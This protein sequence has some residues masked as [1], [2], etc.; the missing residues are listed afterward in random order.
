MDATCRHTSAQ[1]R[2]ASAHRRMISSSYFSH[3]AAHASQSSAQTPQMRA[4]N[5]EFRPTDLAQSAVRSAQVRHRRA[6]RPMRS[7]PIQALAQRDASSAHS[8]Q[9][10]TQ[11]SA[12]S[13]FAIIS[14][15]LAIAVFSDLP[16]QFQRYRCP[17]RESQ[18][19]FDCPVAQR[20]L[21]RSAG[22]TSRLATPIAV[23]A[24]ALGP[25][26]RS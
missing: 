7:S 4:I 14:S 15:L 24:C 11:R 1:R 13:V 9:A 2:H 19:S 21:A 5:G 17:Q 3:S 20:K 25:S 8:K 12:S 10:Q 16:A 6:Q 18:E 26:A 23:D 22:A